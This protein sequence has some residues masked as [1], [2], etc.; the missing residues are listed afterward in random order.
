MELVEVREHS[1]SLLYG[2][3]YPGP[4][5]RLFWSMRYYPD[6]INA[7]AFDPHPDTKKKNKNELK[8]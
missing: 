6:A 5:T 7:P 8:S 4:D 3:R 2:Y 1:G